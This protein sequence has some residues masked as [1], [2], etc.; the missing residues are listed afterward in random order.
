MH[1]RHLAAVDG[2]AADGELLLKYAQFFKPLGELKRNHVP[3]DLGLQL[4][5]DFKSH[6]RIRASASEILRL[7]QVAYPVCAARDLLQN[8]QR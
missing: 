8:L 7:Y 5:L 4:D 1:V 3:V 2:I 6:G